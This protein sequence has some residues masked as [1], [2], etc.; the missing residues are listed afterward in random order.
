MLDSLG[1]VLAD[2]LANVKQASNEAD[3]AKLLAEA[4]TV[5][6]AY[7]QHAA[8]CPTIAALDKNPFM[9]LAIGTTIT[10]ALDA[11]LRSVRR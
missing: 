2:V 7:G 4:Q 8:T 5:I 9:P 10:A 3:R 6:H 11:I 1:A